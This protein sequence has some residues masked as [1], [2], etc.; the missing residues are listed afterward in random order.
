MK[1]DTLC[2]ALREPLGGI[3]KVFNHFKLKKKTGGSHSPVLYELKIKAPQINGSNPQAFRTNHIVLEDRP[4]VLKSK[5]LELEQAG[6][7]YNA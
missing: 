3:L 1:P 2:R 4:C 6:L 7:A 5:S